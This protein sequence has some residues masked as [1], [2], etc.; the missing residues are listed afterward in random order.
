MNGQSRKLVVLGMMTKIP[1]AG[2]VW[3]T[4]HYLVGFQRL[5]F[6]P[7]YVEAHARTPGMLM[8]DRAGRRR[9][10]RSRVHRE[11]SRAFGFDGPLGLP[12]AARR[13]PRLRDERARAAA[14]LRLGRAD[15]QPPRRHRA[16]ARALRD[17][18]A[19]LPRD[20]PGAAP[21]RARTT[22]G[23]TRSTSSSRTS[24][25]SPS[26]RTTAG[27]AAACRSPTASRFH[28]TR[29]PVV[30][31][32]WLGGGP[33]DGA[34]TTVGNW[35]QPW[36]EVTFD[37]ERYGWSKDQEFRKFLDLPSLTGQTLRARALELRRRRTASCSRAAAGACAHAL[38]FSTDLDAYRD[39]VRELAR[40]VHGRQG[41]ERPAAHRLVQRPQRDLSR[42][43]SAGRHAG[44][45]LRHRRC[46]PARRSSRFDVDRRRRWPR[47]R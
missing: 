33:D 35:S 5:G 4:L 25:S 19:R 10:P 39:Y 8:R 38:D 43:R 1:V 21:G 9:R 20:R 30:L 3:Q 37:G 16:A 29:Q 44:H 2:V 46:R 13:R 28:P 24:P 22:S 41:P 6:D 12:R 7:Y 26:A 42:R 34:Y 27:P 36:R 15:R 23:S 40:R 32:F 45:R 47:S 18:P 31:D 11:R 14:A 17:R